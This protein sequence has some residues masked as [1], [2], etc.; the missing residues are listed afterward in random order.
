MSEYQCYEFAALDRPLS[1]K[2]MAELRAISTRAEISPTRFWNEYQWGDLKADPAKLMERYFDAHLYFANWGT[3]RLMLR[4]PGSRI[5]Q[6]LLK[7]YFPGRHAARL[8]QAGDH[9]LVDLS[10]DDEDS[11]GEE[12]PGSLATLSPVRA[13]VMRGDLRAAYLAWLLAVQAGEVDDDDAEPP[14]PPGLRDL[15]A[16]QEA[17]AEVLRID[18]DLVAAAASGSAAATDDREP[19]LR[20]VVALSAKEKDAWLKRA[21]KQPDLAIG[22]ELARTF[23]AKHKAAAVG[24][25][26]TVA[27]LRSQAEVERAAREQQEA[28]RAKRAQAA[29]DGA[30]VR[31]L[32]K[33]ARDVNGAWSKLTKL[34]ENSQ[35]D[36][37]VSLA[38]DLRDL[39]AR[40]GEQATFAARFAALRKSQMRRRGF[41][42][43]WKRAEGRP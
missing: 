4:I 40:E 5:D 29:A 21:V 6:K 24:R 14:V 12:S 28:A 31:H 19:L 32:A 42:E 22:T 3:R 41:F 18:P 2:Q 25:R 10:S 23:R 30:R 43:R 9:L 34:V 7:P 39:A 13:E 38:I 33:L 1:A 37:A 36:E 35:Y 17:M 16:A 8:T 27:E 15:T 20:W 11:E 26:R